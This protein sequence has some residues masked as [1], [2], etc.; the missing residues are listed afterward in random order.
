MVPFAH[1]S[2]G[3]GSI[4][5]PASI[6][7]LVGLKPTRQRLYQNTPPLGA[8][9]IGVRLAVTRSVRDQAQILNVSEKKGAGAD[10]PPTGFIEGPSKK[11]LKIA[12]FTKAYDGREPHADVKRAAERAARLCANLGHNVEAV[13]AQIVEAAFL[14]N[15][16]NVWAVGAYDLVKECAPYR[17]DAGALGQR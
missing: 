10:Y 3:G 16:M 17:P 14:N 15:F 12:F 9:D 11:R 7:G 6:C 2:D 8:A 13:E 1:A 4:R 5:I